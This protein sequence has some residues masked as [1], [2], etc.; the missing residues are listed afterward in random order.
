MTFKLIHLLQT[1]SNA[2]LRTVV[3]QLT[4]FQLTQR[5]AR[6]FCDSWAYCSQHRL[7][8]TARSL[9]NICWTLNRSRTPDEWCSWSSER[10][11]C[12]ILLLSRPAR[13]EGMFPR[14][15]PNL[16][17]HASYR[18]VVSAL[19]SFLWI[20]GG[21]KKLHTHLFHFDGVHNNKC[22]KTVVW[23]VFYDNH[24]QSYVI[25]LFLPLWC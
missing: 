22:N 20:Q 9:V 15:T 18:F 3:Q 17:V 1:F 16:M 8:N 21:P 24:E 11:A 13:S 19:C 25:K 4:R 6:S 7:N 14:C 2:I 12:R 23:L 10:F 5:V